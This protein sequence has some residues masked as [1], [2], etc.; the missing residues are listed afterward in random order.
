M[1]LVRIFCDKL[2]TEN[3]PRK[4]ENSSRKTCRIFPY[5]EKN[6]FVGSFS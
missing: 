3:L 6:F 4:N 5:E 2:L 1:I